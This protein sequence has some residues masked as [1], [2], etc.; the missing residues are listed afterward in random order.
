MIISGAPTNYS[1]GFIFKEVNGTC[2]HCL[3]LDGSSV[4]CPYDSPAVQSLKGSIGIQGKH[5]YVFWKIVVVPATC[6]RVIRPN[7]NLNHR[8]QFSIYVRGV[9]D[10]GGE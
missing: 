1:N 4:R 7:C 3:G 2:K 6:L 5:E 8:K 10:H 9:N